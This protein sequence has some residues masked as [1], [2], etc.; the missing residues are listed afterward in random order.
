MSKAHGNQ[1]ADGDVPLP[2][3]TFNVYEVAEQ[4]GISH[5]TVRRA[6]EKGEID[7]VR[8]GGRRLVPARELQRVAGA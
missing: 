2:R 1:S 7:S 3:L 6:I 8:I 4:L 5:W